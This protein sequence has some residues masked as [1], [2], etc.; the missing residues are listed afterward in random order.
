MIQC[1]ECSKQCENLRG[2]KSHM[3]RSH[4][5][6]SPEQLA[7]VAETVSSEQGA[8]ATGYQS[9]E[10][11]ASAV[12]SGILEN[13]PKE[14]KARKPRVTKAQKQASQE[15]QAKFS[16]MRGQ[17]AD[18]IMRILDTMLQVSME[19]DP[20]SPLERSAMKDSLEFPLEVLN[21]E[22]QVEPMNVNLTSFWWTLIMPLSMFAMIL[23]NRTIGPL[24]KGDKKDDKATKESAGTAVEN[25]SSV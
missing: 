14:P 4:G 15:L 1:Q 11:A 18:G 25:P 20:M 5:G 16:A 13:E 2:W 19:L 21:I 7:Q 17:F 22:F 8:T 24:L 6:W 10:D 3:S 23:V 9:F 12:A